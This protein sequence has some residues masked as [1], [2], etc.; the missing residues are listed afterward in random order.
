MFQT[1]FNN[2]EV[3]QLLAIDILLPNIARLLWTY[4]PSSDRQLTTTSF[5]STSV[6]M[7]KIEIFV[8]KH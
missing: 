6:V 5:V 2:M 7:C 4:V 1:V 8:E 3:G